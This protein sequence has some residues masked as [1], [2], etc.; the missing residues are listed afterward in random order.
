M[1]T[2]SK[3]NNTQ[4]LPDRIVFYDGDC[5]FCNSSVQFILD[6]RKR[7]IHF[8]ALQSDIAE[9]VLGERGV[10]IQMNTLYYL[11][12]KNLCSK[13]TAALKIAR[14]LKGAWPIIYWFGIIFPKT[15]RNWVYDQ[16]AKRRHKIN[17]GL[18]AMPKPEERKLFLDN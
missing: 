2:S 7:A 3:K 17:P 18:C 13:S 1:S 9:N 12:N 5:G 14:H 4:D 15:F 11:E 8:A 6:R 10:T 16:V